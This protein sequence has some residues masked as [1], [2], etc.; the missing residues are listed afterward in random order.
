[1]PRARA[2]LERWLEAERDQLVLWLPVALGSGVAAW[3][4]L[5]DSRQWI[6]ALL[7]M[8]A[9]GLAALAIGRHGR[10]A[11]ALAIGAFA[12]ALG[13]VL[14]WWRAEHV[15]AP[16]LDRPVIAR[17]VARVDSVDPL[18]ARELVRLEVTAQRTLS[19]PCTRPP[20]P[21]PAA[22]PPHFR[23]N[24][25]AKDLPAGLG[26]GAVI[27]LRARL[28]PPPSA[29]VPGA[30]D[31]A[32]AAWFARIGA[33]GRGFAPVAVLKPA[34]AEGEGIR[35]RLTRHIETMLPGSAGGIA[36]ALVT[37]DTGAIAEGDA[38][39]MRRAGLAHLLSISGLHVTA[40]VGITFWLSMRLLALSPWVALRWSVPM[41]AAV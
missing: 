39:A 29:G 6:A 31:F 27:G 2:T 32:Q 25:D 33:T 15:A 9:G 3:Y 30:Y 36:T 13:L 28:M 26:R 4:M 21:P 5:D 7:A 18:P 35:A 34:A 11:R 41:I 14:I 16:V 40:V 1:M 20:C 38:D 23:V 12:A 8:T 17:F 10:A 19:L 22:L 37:G 24:L